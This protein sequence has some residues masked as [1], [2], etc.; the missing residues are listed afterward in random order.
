MV[1]HCTS[2]ER[3]RARVYTADIDTTPIPAICRMGFMAILVKFR[4]SGM[5]R[6]VSVCSAYMPCDS[7]GGH[8]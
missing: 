3:P 6:M 7:D 1:L 8:V 4:V 2:V 5:S